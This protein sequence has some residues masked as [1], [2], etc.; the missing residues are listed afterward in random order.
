MAKYLTVVSDTHGSTYD[1]LRLKGDFLVSD[2]VV[3]LGDG[4]SDW[5]ELEDELDNKLV[6]VNGNCDITLFGEKEELFIVEGVK[7]L[8]V[9]GDRFGVKSSLERLE[10]YAQQKGVNVVLFGHTHIPLVQKRGDI[11]FVNPGTLS[12]HGKE[13]TFA[14][15]TV[16][17][18]EVSAKIIS[19]DLRKF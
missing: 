19:I 17:N 16:N 13:K 6:S 18:G 1:L 5:Y 7:F 11:L 8:A 2:K 9:H 3:F 15:L 10:S 14:F 12:R 4:K